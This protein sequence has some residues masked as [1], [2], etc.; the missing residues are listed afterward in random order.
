M[1][2]QLVSVIGVLAGWVVIAVPVATATGNHLHQRSPS[3]SGIARG[4]AERDRA[5]ASPSRRDRRTG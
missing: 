3:L 2:S 4:V 5:E 1:G